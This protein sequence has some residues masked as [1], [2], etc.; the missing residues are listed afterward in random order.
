MRHHA[1][2]TSPGIVQEE[3]FTRGGVRTGANEQDQAITCL[4]KRR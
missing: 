3:T 1:A 2:L 4:G